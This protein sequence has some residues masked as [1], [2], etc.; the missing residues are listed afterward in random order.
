MYCSRKISVIGSWKN[1]YILVT[2]ESKKYLKTFIWHMLK[3]P[4]QLVGFR[5][6]RKLFD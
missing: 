4:Y 2:S 6:S 1:D 3:S 5:H